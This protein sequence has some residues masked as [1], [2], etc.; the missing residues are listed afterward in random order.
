MQFLEASRAEI[1][2]LKN[3]KYIIAYTIYRAVKE[4]SF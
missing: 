4:Q 2:A 1:L 3:Y